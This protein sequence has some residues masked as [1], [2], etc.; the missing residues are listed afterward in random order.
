MK[1]MWE[2]LVPTKFNSVQGFEIPVRVRHHRVWDARVRKLCGGLTVMAPNIK[3]EWMSP[4]GEVFA[5]RMIPVRVYCTEVEM[6]IIATF[7]KKH[8][9]QEAV[10][11]YCIAS[12]VTIF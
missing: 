3:G 4:T 5:E 8:Y 9:N 6:K 12:E 2:I 11:F 10:M 7:T 1:K